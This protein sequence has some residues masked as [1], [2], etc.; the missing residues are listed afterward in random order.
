MRRFPRILEVESSHLYDCFNTSITL[1]RELCDHRF[2]RIIIEDAWSRCQK[3]AAEDSAHHS[4]VRLT[5]Q[6][7]AGVDSVDDVLTELKMALSVPRLY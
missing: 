6:L 7:T 4:V 3:D 1:R 5:G 2:K